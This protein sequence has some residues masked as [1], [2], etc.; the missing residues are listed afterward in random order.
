MFSL[1]LVFSLQMPHPALPPPASVRVLPTHSCLTALA[2]PYTG[3]S[4]GPGTFPP[5]DDR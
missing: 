2:L 1:F 4:T 5:I 3:A